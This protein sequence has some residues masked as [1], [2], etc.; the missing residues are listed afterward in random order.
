ML[1]IFKNIKLNQPT[2]F[3][4]KFKIHSYQIPKKQTIFFK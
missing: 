4:L 2:T 3:D 1:L